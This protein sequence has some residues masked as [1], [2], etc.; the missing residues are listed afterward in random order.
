[1]ATAVVPEQQEVS[2]GDIWVGR[3]KM[4]LAEEVAARELAEAKLSV[5]SPQLQAQEKELVELRE[6]VKSLTPAPVKK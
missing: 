5:L 6:Q 3:L 4:R 1:M 2:L